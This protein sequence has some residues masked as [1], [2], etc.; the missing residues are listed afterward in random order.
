MK[1]KFNDLF[2]LT[3]D[4]R[5][6][7]TSMNTNA[8]RPNVRAQ[9]NRTGTGSAGQRPQSASTPRYA[10]NAGYYKPGAPNASTPRYAN[11]AGYYRPGT[12]NASTPRAAASANRRPSAIAG[13]NAPQGA[14]RY[15]SSENNQTVSGDR[16]NRLSV[17]NTDRLGNK[18]KASTQVVSSKAVSS[19]TNNNKASDTKAN[20]LRLEFSEE[21]LLRGLIM[22]E[23]LG[24]P[25]CFR[26]GR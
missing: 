11:N 19:M 6:G 18:G 20:G 25:K 9:G 3:P 7:G 8:M 12:P 10:N 22:S 16:G 1:N 17:D 23:I 13:R 24:R 4:M 26:T 21:N 5:Q 15:D 14:V 2:A